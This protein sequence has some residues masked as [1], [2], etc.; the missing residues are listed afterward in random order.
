MYFLLWP[1][2]KFKVDTILFSSNTVN[3]AIYEAQKVVIWI[4]SLKIFSYLYHILNLNTFHHT[5]FLQ[6]ILEENLARRAEHYFSEMKRVV[7]G[8]HNQIFF[9]ALF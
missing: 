9:R 5:L 2:L 1:T 3:P 4:L 6:C 8:E 7:K